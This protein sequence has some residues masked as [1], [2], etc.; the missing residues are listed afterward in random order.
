ML[1]YRA[2]LPLS[3]QTLTF[4]SDL[5]RTH[6]RQVG[7]IWRKL[8]PGQQALLVLVYLRKGEPFVQVG[9]GFDVSTTTCWRY[10]NETVN[11]LA[12]RAPRLRD[13]VRKAKRDGMAYVIIDGTLIPI[14]RIA[15]D[16][17]FY[18]GKHKRHGVNVQVI[19]SPDGTILW[20]SDELP[21]S[22]H[23]TAAA[24]I[25][26]ILAALHEAELI[27]LADKGYHGYDETGQRVIT[28]YKG[29]KKPQ[30]QKDANRA[31]ARLRGPGERAN[32]Q[33]KYWRVLHKVRVSPHRVGRL[34]KA[35]HVLQNYEATA[36]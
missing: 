35:I 25:W 9:A 10:V 33:L 28:P 12:A 31:H 1:F 34:A 5:I 22:T 32:A 16:R 2:A 29:R 7:S 19:A 30:S 15:A 17:P 36:G 26:N 13:A 11:L 18:S 14:D 20:V 23:D 24:R 21:G 4:V 3:R 8:N 27:A 6:R